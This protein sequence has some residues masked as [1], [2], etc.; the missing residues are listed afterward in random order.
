[1][2]KFNIEPLIE[3]H[4]KFKLKFEDLTVK[5]LF[6][7]VRL[8]EAMLDMVTEMTSVLAENKLLLDNEKWNKMIDLKWQ[9]NSEWKKIH[10]E[11]TAQ[12]VINELFLERDKEMIEVKKNLTLLKQKADNIIEY[13]NLSK[14]YLDLDRDTQIAAN[15]PYD[16]Q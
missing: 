15:Q 14:K 2:E 8:K 1:M 4:E 12:A 6:E 13:V 11:S 10:T 16:F 5:D 9:L 7:W 3:Q